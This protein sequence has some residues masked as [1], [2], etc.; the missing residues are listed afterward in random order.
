MEIRFCVIVRV[1]KIKI[2]ML[3][4][5]RKMGFLGWG[6]FRVGLGVF[7]YN[8]DFVSYRRRWFE[9]RIFKKYFVSYV[10]FCNDLYNFELIVFSGVLKN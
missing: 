3:N 6:K 4:N 1:I 2:L 7:Y 8:W 9:S 10:M 5:F